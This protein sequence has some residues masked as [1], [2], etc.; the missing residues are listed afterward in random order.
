MPGNFVRSALFS[1]AEE[2]ILEL[3]GRPLAIARR[4][5]IPV[6]ALHDPDIPLPGRP[7]YA[8]L[9][10]AAA[11]CDCP[12]FG[13]RLGS[14]TPLASIIGPLWVLV[15]NARTLRQMFEDLA[16]NFDIYTGV[17]T[18]AVEPLQQ[19][20]VVSWSSIAGQADSEVQMAELALAVM[21]Q[22]VRR[23]TDPRWMPS[24]VDF[25][26]AAPKSLADHRAV[27]GRNV[28]FNRDRNA[29]FIERALLERPV[30]IAGSRS[31]A[32]VGTLLRRDDEVIDP[33]IAARVESVVRALL[34][35]TT[36]ALRDV[37]QALGVPLRTL[38]HRLDATGHRFKD[39]KDHVRADLALKY[40]RHSQLGLGEIA[41]ILGYSELSAF[42]RSFRRWHGR[43]ATT[44]R[45][46]ARDAVQ[47]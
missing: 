20:M 36:C 26:H 8:F 11:M 27:F 13:L 17:A 43:A 34:P 47:P 45:R 40:L 32:L 42:S 7:A 30:N 38:Q 37:S 29:M 24:N 23:V 31:R 21:A 6:E 4:A 44:V 41:E 1:G 22:E 16:S 25:R 3:R 39:I 18:V 12:T 10:H 15:R 9:E 46:E 14:N 35:F 19:G 5:S 33:S 2:L 28:N